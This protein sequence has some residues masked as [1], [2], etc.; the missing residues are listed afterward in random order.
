M[1]FFLVEFLMGLRRG[2]LAEG[3]HTA[4]KQVLF[5]FSFFLLESDIFKPLVA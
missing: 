4:G 3:R 2:N 1:V 5:S